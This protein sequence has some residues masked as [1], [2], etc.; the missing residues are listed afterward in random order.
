[1][2][3]LEEFQE[4][5]SGWALTQ[6][7]NLTGHG[8]VPLH[9]TSNKKEKHVNLL[10]VPD[11]H[12]GHV[13]HF[14]WIKNLSRFVSSQLSKRKTAQYICDRCLHYFHTS[15][16]LAVHTVDYE[17]L[18]NSAV[19][20]PAE[21]KNCLKFE[22][23]NNKERVPMVVYA[24][25]ECVLENQ[26]KAVVDKL[27]ETSLPPREAF[28]SSLTGD[29]VTESKYAHA[30]NMWQRFNI[31]NLGSY[32]DL[33][34]KTDVLLLADVFK[35][36]RRECLASYGLD[37]AHFYT[38]PGYTLD[39]MLKYT[40]VTFKLLTDIDMVMYVE[41]GVRG[42]LSQCSN[43]YA[44][45]NNRY[46]RSHDL[47]E[48]SSYL[49]YYDVNNLYGWA[50]CQPLPYGNFAWV[51]NAY[52]FNGTTVA[53]D[54]NVGYILEVDLT[55]PKEL[56]D[57]HRD[58]PF[59]PTR[60][61]PPGKHGKNHVKLLATVFNKKRYVIHYLN[62]QQC[63]RYGLRL[64][65]IHRILRFSQSPWLRGYIELNTRFR[66]NATNEFAKNFYKLMNNAVFGKTMKN[67]RK[68][69]DVRLVTK[70]E[71]RCGAEALIAKPNFH[72]CSV[73]AEDLV[74]IELRRLEV[75]FNKPL[76][77]GMC[78]LDISKTCLYEFHYD[79]MAPLYGYDCKILYTDTDSLIY[80]IK[81]ED[82]YEDVKRDIA[83]FDTSDY[84][85]DNLY[86]MPRANKKVPGLMKDE[87]NGAVMTE[88]VGLRAKMYATQVGDSKCTK[89]LHEVFTMSER[90]LALSPHD[91]NRYIIHGST[92]TLPW[93]H[94]K[95][96]NLD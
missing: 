87:N 86:N 16:K 41:R 85:A 92:D 47:S 70:W 72:S 96:P 19:V 94:Y 15:D 49:M 43:R 74:A 31:D 40:C 67:V 26:D 88:F 5:D 29:T 32:S 58:L 28:Y 62:L 95:I 38:L 22:N 50:M 73:F 83:R 65:R 24:D 89:K 59:C 44:R 9:L 81:C 42:G 76:Y 39:A 23:Y 45:A 80:H 91:D 55:Y 78:I 69:T 56:H 11:Q 79:Y 6:I 20:L 21:E 75:L 25:L 90:K 34:L 84:P 37:L 7:L 46:A 53:A 35:N 57:A 13:G 64:T 18:N 12:N 61:E 51:E 33:Y 68:Y 3:A 60:E 14:A 10:Y 54:S 82:G 66:A 48:P 52:E 63:L 17:R 4:R 30:T 71:G 2:T 8:Y 1:M 27:L 77:V 36:F 93:G